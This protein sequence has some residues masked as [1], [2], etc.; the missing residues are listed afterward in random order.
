MRTAACLSTSQGFSNAKVKKKRENKRNER[1]R[2]IEK[3]NERERDI[4]KNICKETNDHYCVLLPNFLL[5]KGFSN[6]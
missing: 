2:D 6:A 3:T 5:S 1:D 4:E